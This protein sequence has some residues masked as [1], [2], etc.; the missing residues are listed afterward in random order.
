MAFPLRLKSIDSEA[1]HPWKQ[2]SILDVTPAFGCVRGKA[3]SALAPNL[4]SLRVD[5]RTGVHTR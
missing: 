1:T 5:Q 3:S 4:G 2:A